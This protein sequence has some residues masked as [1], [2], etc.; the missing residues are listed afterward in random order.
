MTSIQPT[1]WYPLQKWLD[2]LGDIETENKTSAMLTF[3]D[4]GQRVAENV[5]PADAQRYV[6]EKGFVKFMCTFGVSA[7]QCDHRGNVGEC[8]AEEVSGQ[9]V[10]CILKS[11]PYPPDFWYG[12]C[13]GFAKRF[14]RSFVVHYEDLSMRNPKPG[15]D[16]VIRIAVKQ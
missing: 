10:K 8:Y 7:Y 4:I 16:V 12:I 11:T 2:V 13:Y 9:E 14:C 6:K 1:Q 5:L 3:V 15:E